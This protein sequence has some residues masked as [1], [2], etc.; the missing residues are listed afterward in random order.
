MPTKALYRHRMLK[1]D[2]FE[3]EYKQ[4]MDSNGYAYADYD[5]A[6]EWRYYQKGKSW[7]AAMLD[8]RWSS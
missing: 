1:K 4:Y 6:T 8:H 7:F 5:I 2:Q 3:A